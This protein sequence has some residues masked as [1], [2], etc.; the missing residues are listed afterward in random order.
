MTK[1]GKPACIHVA[2]ILLGSY[3][4]GP[5]RR[6]VVFVQG[7]S[8]RCPGCANKDFWEPGVGKSCNIKQVAKR[9]VSGDPEG[10]TISGGE[11]TDQLPAVL[12]LCDK[13]HELKPDM[14]II[15]YSGKH[16]CDIERMHKELLGKIDLVYADPFNPKLAKT[17]KERGSGLVPVGSS[18]QQVVHISG[19]YNYHSGVRSTPYT[20]DTVFELRVGPDG[21]LQL[22]GFY[23]EGRV[24]ECRS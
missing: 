16:A 2:D 17:E 4:S 11:P 18:N 3:V 8:I 21:T 7:C 22:S 14:P 10:V 9:L 12:E 15:M 13:I 6:N 19:R 24:D 20:T 23:D 5:G 1:T